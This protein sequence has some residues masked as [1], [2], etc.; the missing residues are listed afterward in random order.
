[1]YY[2]FILLSKTHFLRIIIINMSNTTYG[3]HSFNTEINISKVHTLH[4]LELDPS[5]S[6]DGETHDFWEMLYVISGSCTVVT[7][8]N[9]FELSQE[10]LIFHKPN[11]FHSLYCNGNGYTIVFVTS[12]NC[13]SRIMRYFNEQCLSLPIELKSL[14]GKVITESRK[15]FNYSSMN[16][17]D[18]TFTLKK[19]AP[20]GSEQLIRLYL[21]QFLILLLQKRLLN[22]HKMTE[23]LPKEQYDSNLVRE[24]INN[25]EGL[26]YKDLNINELCKNLHYG[27]SYIYSIFKAA[28]GA[29][30][31]DYYN[32]LKIDEAKRLFRDTDLSVTEIADKLN[33]SNPQYFSRV[34]KKYAHMTP[35]V[36]K[37]SLL[38][39]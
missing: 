1:M 37:H 5:Y 39:K 11:E 10:D 20:I 22:I 18:F 12:F 32:G 7:T 4:Y 17:K 14:L 25:L 30:I 38:A 31:N 21:E 24:I 28:T 9:R 29:G 6:N 35:L 36:Y 2:V 26:I 19:D 13:R 23:Y 34:F 15:V 8:N 33:Y 27:R 16:G 3:I